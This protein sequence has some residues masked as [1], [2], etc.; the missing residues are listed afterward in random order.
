LLRRPPRSTPLYSSAASDVYKRQGP[1]A[2]ILTRQQL[3]VLDRKVYASSAGVSRG[4]YILAESQKGADGVDVLLLASGSEVHL[5]LEARDT[6]GAEGVGTRVVS[7]HSWELFAQ[8]DVSY[9]EEVIPPDVRVR[10]AVEAGVTQGW[11]R[12]TG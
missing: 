11:E 4:A 6:L 7:I 1:V 9:R 5:A 3:P 2:L 8:E 10:V 12:F